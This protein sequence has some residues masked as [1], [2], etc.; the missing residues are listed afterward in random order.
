MNETTKVSIQL[1]SLA[2]RGPIVITE[3]AKKAGFPFN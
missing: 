2:S 3:G 1:I